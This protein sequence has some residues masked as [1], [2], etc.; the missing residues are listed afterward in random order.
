MD[1]NL[2]SWRLIPPLEADGVTQ[3]AID[4]WLL[5][6][7]QLGKQ[8]AVL[9]FYTWTKPTISLGYHQ[10]HYPGFW[11]DLAEAG[12]IDLVRRPTGGRGV[13]HQGDLTYAVITSDFSGKRI[14]VYQQICQFLIQGWHS[15]G[16]DLYYGQ[17][18]RDYLRNPNCFGTATGAD[19]VTAKGDKLI[20][21][22]QVKKGHAVLQHGSMRLNPHTELH[23]KVFQQP[24]TS[25][26]LDLPQETIIQALTESA[27]DCFEVELVVQ[28]LTPEEWGK[29]R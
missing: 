26:N 29:I 7:H 16:V 12:E 19:L 15:L 28:A 1:S 4:R 3:M 17:A 10:R 20:G 5:Q 8:P 2:T 14:E 6:Q 9:R 11:D 13:L 25:L 18:G 22:A 21:S 24:L 23:E 27:A